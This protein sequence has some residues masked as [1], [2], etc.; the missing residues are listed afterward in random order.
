MMRKFAPAQG[1]A[2]ISDPRLRSLDPTEGNPWTITPSG[3]TQH[4]PVALWS[5]AFRPAF[6]AASLWA[7]LALALW[8]RLLATGER[9]PS[10]FDPVTWHIHAM[11]FGFVPAAIAGFMLTAMPNWTGRPSIKGAALAGLVVLWLRGRITG[12]ISAVLPFWVAAAI[13]LAFPFVLCAVTT[14]DT[15]RQYRGRAPS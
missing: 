5:L 13:D 14:R 8:L 2:A 6:L 11:L 3:T 15:S 9:L 7:A 1:C 12:L 4:Q 10:W